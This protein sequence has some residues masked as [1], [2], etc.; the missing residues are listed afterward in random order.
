[1]KVTEKKNPARTSLPNELLEKIECPFCGNIEI[2]ELELQGYFCTECNS[3][4]ILMD[5]NGDKGYKIKVD[6]TYAWDNAIWQDDEGE[7]VNEKDD[8]GRF[9]P[10]T[11]LNELEKSTGPVIAIVKDAWINTT[12]EITIEWR[13]LDDFE[14]VKEQKINLN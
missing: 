5:T 4:I 3:Q 6:P 1:M 14:I 10:K 11:K 12:K 9:I 13:E 8:D 2:A 7:I